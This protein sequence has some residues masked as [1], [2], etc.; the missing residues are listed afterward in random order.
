MP[1]LKG[2]TLAETEQ[3]QQA[4]AEYAAAYE[5]LECLQHQSDLIPIGDQKTGCIGEFYAYLYLAK[6]HPDAKLSYGGHNQKGWDIK[7]RKGRRLRR[8]QVKTVSEYSKTRGISPVHHGWD[9]LYVLYL[10][11]DFKPLGFWVVRDKSIVRD[12][13]PLKGCKCP[14]PDASSA[15]SGRIPFGENRVAELLRAL[16]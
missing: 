13:K 7:V 9:E 10:G 6:K 1:C 15:G 14:T 12:G 5:R 16:A 4:I 11:R 8:V 2:R 3:I